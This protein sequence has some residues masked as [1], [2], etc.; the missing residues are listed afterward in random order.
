MDEVTS[1]GGVQK[2]ALCYTQLRTALR[3]LSVR[4]DILYGIWP[5]LNNQC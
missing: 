1:R 4:R 3:N 2:Y 5:T